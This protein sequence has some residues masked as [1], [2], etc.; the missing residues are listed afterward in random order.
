MQPLSALLALC[1]G[2]PLITSALTHKRP[3]MQSF[4]VSFD[5]GHN[6]VLNKGR[7]GQQFDMP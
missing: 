2:N 5:V 6:K 7:S 1:E 4:A 3:V